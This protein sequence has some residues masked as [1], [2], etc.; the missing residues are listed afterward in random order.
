MIKMGALRLLFAITLKR[1]EVSAGMI[2]DLPGHSSL[3]ITQNYLGSFTDDAI[4]NTAKKL[5]EF[6]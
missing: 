1:N 6:D 4:I 3:K 5:I 2:G